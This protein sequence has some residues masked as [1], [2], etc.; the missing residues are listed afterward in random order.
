VSQSLTV[1]RPSQAHQAAAVL[2]VLLGLFTVFW[3]LPVMNGGAEDS[4]QVP[5][6]VVILGFAIGILCCVSS[7]GI[8]RRQRWGVVLTIVLNALSF[9]TGAPGILF[10]DSTFLVVS[11]VVGCVLNVVIVY[12]LLR[13]DRVR[14]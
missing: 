7:Y 14:A 1:R 9:L 2:N 4:D 6:P 3:S 8:W 10:G 11:S 12:L 13:R 5:Y